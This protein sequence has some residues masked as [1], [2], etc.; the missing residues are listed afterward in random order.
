MGIMDRLSRLI[1]ANV[2]H[3]LDRSEDP[4]VMLEQILREDQSNLANARIHVRDMIAHEK[5]FAADVKDARQFADEWARKA[6]A[7]VIAGRD[8]LARL[9]LVRRQDSQENARVSEE[10]LLAQQ[11]AVARIKIQLQQLESRHQSTLSRKDVL[12]ARQK[13]AVAANE[14]ARHLTAFS[15]G[16]MPDEMAR[17]ERKIRASEARAVAT[18]ELAESSI[19]WELSAL[20]DPALESD[21]QALKARIARGEIGPAVG[22]A[23]RFTDF[24]DLDMLDREQEKGVIASGL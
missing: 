11:R 22:E 23:L 2:N 14:V 18:T 10:Q 16:R 12:V 9:A 7:A 17:M 6:E 15:P 8:D 5:A 20:D 21:L 24:D 1:Q 3:Q 13:R 19:D 4:V